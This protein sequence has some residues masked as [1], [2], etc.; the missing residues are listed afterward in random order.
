MSLETVNTKLE[1]YKLITD[2]SRLLALLFSKY[3]DIQEDYNIEIANQLIFNKASH[4]N[5][6][7]K[8]QNI[9]NDKTENIRRFYHKNESTNKIIKLNDYYKNY[10]SFFCKA[11]FADFLFANILKNYQDKKAEIF[12]KDNY[13]N[14]SL[15]KDEEKSKNLTNSST[16][17]SL[18]NITNNKTIFDKKYKNIIENE[19][20]NK[21]L[22]LTLDSF[23]NKKNGNN[24]VPLDK[25][26]LISVNTSDPNNE[27][28]KSFIDCLKNFILLNKVKAKAEK[29][30]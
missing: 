5:I 10:Q 13:G 15:D 29:K 1:A 26:N 9:F 3:G 6:Y 23:L 17:S 16:F 14:S 11:I 4:F 20:M 7:F 8:E 19:D 30:K 27:K 18:D 22:M 21:T 2:P 24:E 28:D 25:G 12:Y